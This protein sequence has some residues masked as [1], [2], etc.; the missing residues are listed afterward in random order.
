MPQSKRYWFT[1]A[2]DGVDEGEFTSSRPS[3]EYM[4]KGIKDYLNK[5]DGRGAYL[6]CCSMETSDRYTNLTN[7]VRSEL[8][9]VL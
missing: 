2:W 9:E 7:Q 1:I 8:K 3:Y 5:W 4:V 6:E